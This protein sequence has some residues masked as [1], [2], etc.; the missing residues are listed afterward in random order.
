MKLSKKQ[1][2]KKLESMA[3]KAGSDAE[4]GYE[5]HGW[6]SDDLS[7]SEAS[8]ATDAWMQMLD[9]EE[10]L[11]LQGLA[12]EIQRLMGPDS[13]PKSAQ[14]VYVQGKVGSGAGLTFTSMIDTGANFSMVMEEDFY[15]QL[16]KIHPAIFEEP[17]KLRQVIKARTAGK[18]NSVSL[19]QK[20]AFTLEL[21]GVKMKAEPILMRG[22]STGAAWCM[23]GNDFC[24]KA[25]CV[26]DFADMLLTV[27]KPPLVDASVE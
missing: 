1:L 18:G 11:E 21:G 12:E 4:S 19:H 16:R 26:L 3:G 9:C 17:V 24:I 15:N 6:A 2:I 8:D 20:G 10:D 22:G 27:K 7:D 14:Q 23:I 5:S 13:K 25:K